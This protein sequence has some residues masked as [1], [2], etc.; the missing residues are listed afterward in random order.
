MQNRITPPPSSRPPARREGSY[1]VRRLTEEVSETTYEGYLSAELLA[2]CDVDYWRVAGDR[3]IP[4][5]V[6][7]GTLVTGYDP[8]LPSSAGPAMR[9]F[10]ERGGHEYLMVTSNGI[11]R[12]MGSA[13][14]AASQVPFRFFET[15]ADAF[16]YLRS[17][18]RW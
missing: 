1:S 6:L 3:A 4:Y 7:D 5:A 13:I 2:A 16:E 12:M 10:R 17:I 11:L 18:R 8:A 14:A 15:R 9:L